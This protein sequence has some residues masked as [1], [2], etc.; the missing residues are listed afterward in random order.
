M[1]NNV[2]MQDAIERAV[3]LS[4][5]NWNTYF[6]VIPTSGQKYKIDRYYDD[7]AEFYALKGKLFKHKKVLIG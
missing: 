1:L 7:K 5:K 4:K 3:A 2:E 6:Q